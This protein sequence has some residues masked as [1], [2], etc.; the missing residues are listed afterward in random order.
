ME[1][2]FVGEYDPD[3]EKIHNLYCFNCNLSK[4]VYN[5][6]LWKQSPDYIFEKFNDWIGFQPIVTDLLY[7]PDDLSTFMTKYFSIWRKGSNDYKESINLQRILIYLKL[8]ENRLD[9]MEMVYYFEKYIGHL[10]NI[11]SEVKKGLHPNLYE[12][13]GTVLDKNDDN[14]TKILRDLKLGQLV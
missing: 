10:S 12:F 7:T 5:E 1:G 14:I 2:S 8:T 4:Y 3:L 6:E 13:V 9:L 11:S